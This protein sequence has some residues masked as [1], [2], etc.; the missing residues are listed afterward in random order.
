MALYR[1]NVALSGFSLPVQRC[2]VILDKGMS[3]WAIGLGSPSWE[4]WSGRS[5]LEVISMEPLVPRKEGHLA[6]FS[7]ERRSIIPLLTKDTR[8][9]SQEWAGLARL[10]I[11]R[12]REQP[13]SPLSLGAMNC[14]MLIVCSVMLLQKRSGTRNRPWDTGVDWSKISEAAIADPSLWSRGWEVDYCAKHPYELALSYPNWHIFS[15]L[16]GK[17]RGVSFVACT[18]LWPPPVRKAM[19]KPA[20][21]IGLLVFDLPTTLQVLSI[22]A[23]LIESNQSNGLNDRREP[24]SQ[25]PLWKLKRIP[26]TVAIPAW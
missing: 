23:F 1:T 20:A 9:L 22:R 11:F 14:R 4:S 5:W 16:R 10:W 13:L 8:I 15:I 3:R 17:G 25:A 26:S 6:T 12:G 24:K 19:H 7:A 21:S 2:V 18:W